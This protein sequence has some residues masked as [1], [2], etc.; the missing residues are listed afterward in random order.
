MYEESISYEIAK[1]NEKYL[2]VYNTFVIYEERK[3]LGN[4]VKIVR[5]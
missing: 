3:K 1:L 5:K 4:I 2:N